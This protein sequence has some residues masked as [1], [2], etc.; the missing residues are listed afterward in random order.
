MPWGPG[1]RD[2]GG[3]AGAGSAGLEPL[4]R[5]QPPPLAAAQ[6]GHLVHPATRWERKLGEQLP[7]HVHA[8]LAI[9]G[10]N[11]LAIA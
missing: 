7:R 5:L 8:Y 6:L 3:R 2:R 10:P 1:G 4:G 11:R 9:A